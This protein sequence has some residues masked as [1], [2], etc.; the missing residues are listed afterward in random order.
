MDIQVRKLREGE[1]RAYLLPYNPQQNLWVLRWAK[2]EQLAEVVLQGKPTLEDI[3]HI[4]LGWYDAEVDKRILSGFRF[5]EAMVWLS[6]ENQ[7][8]YK[9]A[10]DLAVQT[11][12][13]SLPVTFKFGTTEEP[14]YRAFSTLEDLQSF[15]LGSVKYVESVLS[16]GWQAKDKIDWTVYETTE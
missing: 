16:E 11:S 10:Y 6:R 5:E 8:N 15:Y 13:A 1:E 7:F 2:D 14:I 12:G 4:V 3:K 9:V